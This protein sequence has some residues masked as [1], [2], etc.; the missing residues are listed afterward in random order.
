MSIATPTDVET[1]LLRTLTDTESEYVQALLDRVEGILNVSIPDLLARSAADAGYKS[2]V[3]AVEAEAVARVFRNP[4]GMR[5]E[6]DGSYS[7]SLNALVA[8]GLLAI[9]DDEW[10]RLGIGQLGSTRG[11]MDAYAR[12]KFSGMTP[13]LWFQYGWPGNCSPFDTGL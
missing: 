5:Q 4:T 9:T 7:Y 13:D 11:E 12:R 3:I 2:L 8:S 10:L 1:S 6:S